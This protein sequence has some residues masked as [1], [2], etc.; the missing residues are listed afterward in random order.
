[1]RRRSV[2]ALSTAAVRLVS[3][4]VTWAAW[5]WSALGPRRALASASSMRAMP[6][7]IHGATNT[8]P[9]TPTTAASTAPSRPT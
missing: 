6:I 8:T 3:S 2:S 9:I 7:V 1:M 5:T 4:R